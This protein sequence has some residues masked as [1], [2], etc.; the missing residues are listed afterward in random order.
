MAVAARVAADAAIYVVFGR[1]YGVQNPSIIED[2]AAAAAV[3]AVASA[4]S[5]LANKIRLRHGRHSK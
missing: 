3:F 2:V 5:L 1:L 4:A